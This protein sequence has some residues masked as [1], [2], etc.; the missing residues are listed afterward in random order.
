MVFSSIYFLAYF[1]PVVLILYYIL[2][3]SLKNGWLFLASLFFYGWG[4]PVYILI[5]LFST[6][7]DYTNGR[8]IERFDA[9]GKHKTASKA[10]LVVSLVVNL[11]ILCFFKYTDFLLGNLNDAFGLGLP[12]LGLALPIGISFYTFQT[13]SY[14]IDVYRGKV[15]VQHDVISFGMY[16]ALFPQLIAGPIVRYA[17]VALT[18]QPRGFRDFF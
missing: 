17:D 1:L 18:R 15:E 8:L 3:Q 4:E 5:M 13:L 10:V 2:P 14:T 12:V 6:V 9:Q 11:G 16:V 7:F